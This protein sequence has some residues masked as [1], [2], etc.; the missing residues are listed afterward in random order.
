ML[1]LG[2]VT[3]AVVGAEV[4][5]RA[6]HRRPPPRVGLDREE[7]VV[8]EVDVDSGAERELVRLTAV[9]HPPAR[10][11]TL[12]LRADGVLRDAVVH[13]Q[14]LQLLPQDGHV[15]AHVHAQL[16]RAR[17]ARHVAGARK[18]LAR[19]PLE[20]AE[21]RLIVLPERVALVRCSLVRAEEGRDAVL[22]EVAEHML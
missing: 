4:T 18:H 12:P 20:E 6:H 8:D 22:L 10:D 5:A 1:E 15:G 7:E 16:E 13:L 19:R 9:L 3:V 2:L 21:P 17:G 14:E 11:G